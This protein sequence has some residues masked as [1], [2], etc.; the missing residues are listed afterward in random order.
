MFGNGHH[1]FLIKKIKLADFQKYLQIFGKKK[2]QNKLL[3]KKK[4]TISK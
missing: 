4:D 3:K 1:P 2:F